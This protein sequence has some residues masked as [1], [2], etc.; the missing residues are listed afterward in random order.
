MAYAATTIKFLCSYGGKILPRYPDGK[1]RYHGGDTRVLSV[2]RSI[3]FSDLLKKMTELY[4]A[5]VSLR[6]Q[7]PTED[8]DALISIKSDEDLEN[9]IEE[10]DRAAMKIRAFLTPIK[11]PS[12]L[13]PPSSS[14]SESS[15]K[16][17]NSSPKSHISSVSRPFPNA[18]AVDHCNKPPIY[19]PLKFA[20]THHHHH[21][22]VPKVPHCAYH[23]GYHGRI[24]LVH[25]GNYWQ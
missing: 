7:L 3:S 24:Y 8:L 20:T 18:I 10:Y 4:G 9:I 6:C 13:P 12:P 23:A 2:D 16:S 11:T 19:P 25:N 15:P 1:L 14:S 22:V 17:S 5:A 21:H